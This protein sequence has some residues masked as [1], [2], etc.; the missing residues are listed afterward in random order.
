MPS[1]W[2]SSPFSPSFSMLIPSPK[3]CP[4]LFFYFLYY[5]VHSQPRPP[6]LT[7]NIKKQDISQN[8][9]DES[10][11]GINKWV[12]CRSYVL[13]VLSWFSS[14]ETTIKHKFIFEF[15]VLCLAVR[16]C[17]LNVRLATIIIILKQST[18]FIMSQ[19]EG[20]GWGNRIFVNVKWFK[21]VAMHTGT[22]IIALFDRNSLHFTHMWC[23]WPRSTE[24]A[25]FIILGIIPWDTGNQS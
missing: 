8:S 12:S 11:S 3:Y 18:N 20:K 25:L 6:Y 15:I 21:F 24:H 22:I 1:P 4:S 13:G 7:L 19:A 10:L 9:K 2:F 17:E 16:I 23:W 5:M 14:S